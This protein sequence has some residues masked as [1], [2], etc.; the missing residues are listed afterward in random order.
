MMLKT[1]MEKLFKHKPN[2]LYQEFTLFFV[3]TIDI[4]S[5]NIL[6]SRLDKVIAGKMYRKG[7]PD[8]RAL[9]GDEIKYFLKGEESPINFIP[10]VNLNEIS[11]IRRY[12]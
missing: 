12:R 4:N 10:V 2:G 9:F 1:S 8:E 11:Y 7:P 6:N 5:G 3:H